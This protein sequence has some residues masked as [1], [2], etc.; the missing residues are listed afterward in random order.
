MLCATCYV[1]SVHARMGVCLTS[2]YMRALAHEDFIPCLGDFDYY[3]HYFHYCYQSYY[4]QSYYYYD[5]CT[6]TNIDVAI[7]V[8]I[9]ITTTITT[10][11]TITAITF[12]IAITI[13]TAVTITIANVY[14]RIRSTCGCTCA[15]SA[16]SYFS[17]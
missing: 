8:T 17:L 7:S 5:Y 14:T 11:T 2:A 16:Y 1:Y 4:Y 3:R 13:A 6:I 15:H 12:A 10:N 9:T